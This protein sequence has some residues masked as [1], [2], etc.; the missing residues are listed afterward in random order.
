MKIH[1]TVG[2]CRQEDPYNDLPG[3]SAGTG[4]FRVGNYNITN[5]GFVAK[6]ASDLFGILLVY[7]IKVFPHQAFSIRRF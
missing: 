3:T 7:T 4:T 5:H 6:T 1:L 2:M